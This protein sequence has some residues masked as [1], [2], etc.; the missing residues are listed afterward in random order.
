MIFEYLIKI[1]NCLTN[2][3]ELKGNWKAIKTISQPLRL[4]WWPFSSSNYFRLG[5]KI[6][7]K[8]LGILKGIAI[9]AAHAAALEFVIPFLTFLGRPAI[10]SFNSKH[11]ASQ[12]NEKIYHR[13]KKQRGEKLSF[14]INIEHTHTGHALAECER[15]K[16]ITWNALKCI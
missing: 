1:L 8:C 14:S 2:K 10:V 15:G 11:F 6:H 3:Y 12:S 16:I 4:K 5:W 7:I 13:N 9:A